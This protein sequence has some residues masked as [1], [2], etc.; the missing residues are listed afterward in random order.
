MSNKNLILLLVLFVI[1]GCIF[2]APETTYPSVIT[3]PISDVTQTSAICAGEIPYDSTF[4][5]S[6]R[7]ICW[8]TMTSPTI[9]DNIISADSGFGE[10]TVELSELISGTKYYI[11]AYASTG[12]VVGYG[13][14]LSFVALQNGSMTDIDGN[15]YLTVKIGNQ[16]W[17]A[18]NLITTHYKNGDPIPRVLET[19]EWDSLVTGAYCD[20]DDSDSI[21]KE[22]GRLYNWYAVDDSRG[23]APEGWRVPTYDDWAELVLYIDSTANI[24]EGYGFGTE[25]GGKL[26]ET[27]YEHWSTSSHGAYNSLGFNAR[28]GGYRHTNN[29]YYGLKGY[30]FMWSSSET[31]DNRYAFMANLERSDSILNINGLIK[32]FGSNVRCVKIEN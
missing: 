8:S 4:I 28:G 29:I 30:S 15:E 6:D 26:K 2:P 17:M 25:Q 16:W 14:E 21:S 32:Y 5:I 12:D 24:H 7:G 10:F 1:L 11:R 22:Y 13:D 19:G 23:L 9:E 27:G 20:Y 18:E 3:S 31:D